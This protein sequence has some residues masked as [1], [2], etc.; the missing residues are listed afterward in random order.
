M[1]RSHSRGTNDER[2]IGMLHLTS[3]EQII[4]ERIIG[5]RHLR[6]KNQIKLYSVGPTSVELMRK[7]LL[8]C[9]T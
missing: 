8:A 4:D 5:M 9:A 1:R 2:I 6:N 7:E 3:K